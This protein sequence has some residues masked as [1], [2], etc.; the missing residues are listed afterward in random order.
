MRILSI[1]IMYKYLHQKMHEALFLSE[2][3]Y[4]QIPQ[5]LLEL[6]FTPRDV[7]SRHALMKYGMGDYEDLEFLGDAV[8]ELIVVSSC[9]G[10]PLHLAKQIAQEETCNQRL[11]QRIRHL[12]EP[13]GLQGKECADVLEALIGCIFYF[14]N[15]YELTEKWYLSFANLPKPTIGFS[16]QPGYIPFAPLLLDTL[17][18]PRQYILASLGPEHPRLVWLGRTVI[19]L[20]IIQYLFLADVPR[21]EIDRMRSEW[22][23]N[24]VSAR[25]G[26][27]TDIDPDVILAVIGGVY[28]GLGVYDKTYDWLLQL[29]E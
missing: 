12:T 7:G 1:Y 23:P 18:I 14:F 11:Y 20:V 21:Q 26:Y 8:L 29:L 17:P 13:L 9:L 24:N 3:P 19:K 2:P 6:A 15:S 16:Y 25:L 22:S 10:F 27:F 4:N 5:D 28:L